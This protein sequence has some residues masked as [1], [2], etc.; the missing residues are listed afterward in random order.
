MMFKFVLAS[1]LVFSFSGCCT[2]AKR[3]CFPPCDPPKV[4]TVNKCSLPGPVTLPAAQN[5]TEACPPEYVCYD[6]ENAK[7]LVRRESVLKDWIED[8]KKLNEENSE[9]SETTPETEPDTE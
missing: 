8:A 2:F 6:E 3:T 4:I 7:N 1:V 9:S 5:T